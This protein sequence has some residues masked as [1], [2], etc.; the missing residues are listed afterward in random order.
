[1]GE[2]LNLGVQSYS[3]KFIP[4]K[5]DT[6]KLLHDME[7]LEDGEALH[8]GHA[9]SILQIGNEKIVIDPVIVGKELS[10][11]GKKLFPG[12][13]FPPFGLDSLK[14]GQKDQDYDQHLVDTKESVLADLDPNMNNTSVVGEALGAGSNYAFISHLD[15]DHID[16]E[17]IS[18]MI[19]TNPDF[20]VFGPKGLI[21]WVE[22][23]NPNHP[24]LEYVKKHLNELTPN[25]IYAGSTT[26]EA[27]KTPEEKIDLGNGLTAT[28]FEV[29][30]EGSKRAEVTQAFLFE[31]GNT[32]ILSCPEAA[33]SPEIINVLRKTH[34]SE[35][36]LTSIILSTAIYNPDR[37]HEVLSEDLTKKYKD[38]VEEFTAH[39]AYLPF[40]FLALT[41]GKVPIELVHHGFYY[42]DRAEKRNIPYRIP[43]TNDIDTDPQTWMIK[44]REF[45]SKTESEMSDVLEP[46]KPSSFPTPKLTE[47]VKHWD[48]RSK[49][50]GKIRGWIADNPF[51]TELLKLINLPQGGETITHTNQ[52]T[53]GRA[54]ENL[55]SQD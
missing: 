40:I 10:I 28:V 35:K 41:D 18:S 47:R 26:N 6:D 33:L 16:M 31:N 25:R 32:R 45:L 34:S 17:L 8:V 12:R 13:V 39:S 2:E 49:F 38:E 24:K 46:L 5:I 3:E 14:I 4:F 53:M 22:M 1:M 48:T 37:F 55:A 19:D 30:H 23:A 27:N 9:A 15:P 29:V 21:K 51:P 44:F 42:K 7:I 43:L 20:K 50:S 11:R 54:K 36:P 52:P